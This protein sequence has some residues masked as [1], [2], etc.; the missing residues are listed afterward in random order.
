MS[1]YLKQIKVPLR[2]GSNQTVDI[3]TPQVVDNE[4]EKELI[5]SYTELSY[6]PVDLG[7]PS[8]ILWADRNVG[9]ISIE[10]S[11]DI[12][13]WG[14]VEPTTDYNTDYPSWQNYKHCAG[15]LDTLTKYCTSKDYGIKDNLTTLSIEDDA[16]YVNMGTDWR[17]PTLEDFKELVNNTDIVVVTTYGT[18]PVKLQDTSLVPSPNGDILKIKFYNK[19]DSTKYIQFIYNKSRFH[20]TNNIQTSTCGYYYYAYS[21]SY[22]KNWISFDYGTGY[23]RANGRGVRGVTRNPKAGL[24]FYTKRQTDDLMESTE[25]QIDSIQENFVKSSVINCEVGDAIVYN[26]VTH[27]K[28][29]I[30]PENITSLDTQ[31]YNPLGVVT[32]PTSHDVYGT[33]ECAIMSLPALS[34]Y[35]E[36]TGSHNKCYW[37]S[38]STVKLHQYDRVNNQIQCV[39]GATQIVYTSS[40]AYLPSDLFGENGQISYKVENFHVPSPFNPDGTK[41]KLYSLTD[42]IINDDST[43]TVNATSQGLNIRWEKYR[44]TWSSESDEEAYD[45]Q[46]FILTDNNRNNAILKCYFQG[47]QGDYI[48]FKLLYRVSIVSSFSIGAMDDN[49]QSWARVADFHNSTDSIKFVSFN[50]PDSAEHSVAIF[51]YNGRNDPD[52]SVSVVKGNIPI[53]SGEG[54]NKNSQSDFKGKEATKYLWDKTRSEYAPTYILNAA[55]ELCYRYEPTGTKRGDWYLPAAGELGYGVINQQKITKT[56]SIIRSHFNKDYY[57]LRDKYWTSTVSSSNTVK[58]I[59]FYTGKIIPKE[60]ISNTKEYVTRPFLRV[61]IDT[62]E[63]K[64]TVPTRLINKLEGLKYQEEIDANL[65]AHTQNKS[66]PHEVTKDQ[67]GLGRVTNDAQVKRSELGVANGVATLD[68]DGKVPAS[69]LPS[70]VDDVVDVYAT[71][72]VSDS[73]TFSDVALYLDA[74]HTQP[75]T[76]E[77]GKIY[78]N[79]AE[80]E[81]N[82]QFRWSGSVFSQTGASSLIIGDI[83]GTA[84]DGGKGAANAIKI[85]QLEESLNQ[86]ISDIAIY[87]FD[88]FTD[89]LSNESDKPDG[90]ILFERGAFYIKVNGEWTLESNILSNYQKPALLGGGADIFKDRLFR[91]NNTLY[92][93]DN[94]YNELI[95]PIPY[96]TEN[97]PGVIKVLGEAKTNISRGSKNWKGVY[98]GYD[99]VPA[100]YCATNNVILG[101]TEGGYNSNEYGTISYDES[102][103]ITPQINLRIYDGSRDISAD[104]KCLVTEKG[105]Y[106]TLQSYVKTDENGKINSNVIPFDANFYYGEQNNSI[107][108]DAPVQT[109]VKTV[110]NELTGI[111][112]LVAE[113]KGYYFD[114]SREPNINATNLVQEKGLHAVL[115]NKVTVVEGKDLSSND[116]TDADKT[117]LTGLREYTLATNSDIDAII[118]GQTS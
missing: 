45:G 73:G 66:N 30:K 61:K 84:Y 15:T 70:Y 87:P 21:F 4:I 18:Y 27:Q 11:G 36:E 81:P 109:K 40:T 6:T 102:S 1:K 97:I 103:N 101:T 90:T 50:I 64:E 12:F 29:C 52:F 118:N 37:S 93:V 17:I 2:D 23:G 8:G 112:E 76:G 85:S 67:I 75:V 10:D 116:Y 38:A 71:Y 32:I 25:S 96:A 51:L 88:G 92:R 106:K 58:C 59:D 54:A 14:E 98:I 22:S 33:K 28:E 13:R 31:K 62:E 9:A 41:N 39:N 57:T 79:I 95:P 26:K 48:T 47:K 113:T 49:P 43:P 7:L 69:Q 42:R 91:C 83:T 99:G 110:T 68:S 65:N 5:D 35:G 89:D 105:L 74:N 46:K 80:G 20:I 72:T 16:A 82:Y 107:V 53:L 34:L 19:Q 94:D 55:C 44:G 115:A 78:Q 86:A 77:F 24:K 100:V 108:T 104:F 3:V 63:V 56:F 60:N 117:K 114:G 111:D